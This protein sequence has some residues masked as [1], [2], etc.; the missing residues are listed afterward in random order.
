[1]CFVYLLKKEKRKTNLQKL[2][3]KEN[4][5]QNG[6]RTASSHAYTYLYKLLV[7]YIYFTNNT[8]KSG[9]LMQSKSC[10]ISDLHGIKF[11]YFL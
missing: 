9:L 7:K 10:E 3:L 1:M 8:E 2:A 4:C 11:T 6:S 5:T